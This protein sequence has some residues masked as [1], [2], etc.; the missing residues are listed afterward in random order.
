LFPNQNASERSVSPATESAAGGREGE[1]A[2]RWRREAEIERSNRGGFIP[3]A[4]FK[5]FL[6]TIDTQLDI[7]VLSS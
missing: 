3:L 1:G 2:R 5:D 7:E 4:P 6:L